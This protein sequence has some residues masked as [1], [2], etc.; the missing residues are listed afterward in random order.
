MK[1]YGYCRS[2][3]PGNFSG[4]NRLCIVEL[5][6]MKRKTVLIWAILFFTFVGLT[7]ALYLLSATISGVA[8]TCTIGNVD[9]CQVVYNSQYSTIFGVPNS[10]LGSAFFAILFI[11]SAVYLAVRKD[12]IEKILVWFAILGAAFSLY[13]IGIQVF[14]IKTYCMYCL[15][16]AAVSFIILALGLSLKN[17]H[18]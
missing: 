10:V 2:E 16:S 18:G 14:A 8:P 7:N 15:L 13:F 12:I 4:N 1:K 17:K 6:D 11:I 3:S 5:A 9:G